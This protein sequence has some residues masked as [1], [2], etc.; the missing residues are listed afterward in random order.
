MQNVVNAG[1]AAPPG[2]LTDEECEKIFQE[3]DPPIV[4]GTYAEVSKARQEDNKKNGAKSKS[5]N[6]QSEHM[7]AN[8]SMQGKRGDNSSNVPGA[9]G[10]TEGGA[11][12]YNVYDD[13][14]AGTEHKWLTDKAKAYEQGLKGKKPRLSQRLAASEKWTKESLLS[15]DIQRTKGGP[16]RS[17]VKDAPGRT[18]KQKEALAGD[19]AK[20]LAQKAKAQ[21][22]KQ[23]VS[24]DTETR[25]GLVGN[26][27]VTKP[28][29][30]PAEL[31]M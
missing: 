9:E 20:C 26:S 16:K 2:T 21:F 24:P 23:G 7:I 1:G 19:A 25:T 17:R 3:F 5:Q 31:E 11:F 15:D 4:C 6:Q 12:A 18:Q 8:S 27:Q 14:S 13:Q 28:T 29:V 10:Y 30:V 22:A